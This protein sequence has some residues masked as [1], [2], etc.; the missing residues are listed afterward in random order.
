MNRASERRLQSAGAKA[1]RSGSWPLTTSRTNKTLRMN[2]SATTLYSLGF[3]WLA[4]SRVLLSAHAS[5]PCAPVATFADGRSP[6]REWFVSPAGSDSTG[7]GSRAN[8]FRS[9]TRAA[10]R[11]RPGDAIRL[12][13]GTHSPGIYL[14]NLAGTAEAPIWLGGIPG[15]SRPVIAGGSQALHLVRTRYLV[16]EHL[17]VRDATQNGI[18]CDDGGDYANP[19][20]TRHVIFRNLFLHDIGTGGNQDALKLSGVNDY[21]V[22]DC[23]FARTSAGGSGIDHVGCHRGRIVGCRF[24]DM[25]SNAIQCKG[26][27]EDLEI[28]ACQF[29]EGGARA[30]NLGGSTGFEFFRPPLSTSQPNVEARNIRVLASLFRGADAPVAFVGAVDS[31]FANNTIVEP[32][33][34][35]L[36][37]LQETTST[38]PYTFLPCASNRFVNNLV[39]FDRAQLSTFA[40]IGPNTASTTFRFA[41]N[42]WYAADQPARSQPNLPTPE[43]ASVVGRDPRFTDAAA[44]DYS[45]LELSPAAGAGLHLDQVLSDL[46]FRCYASPPSIGAFEAR[47]S[48]GPDADADGD[49]LPDAWERAYGLNPADPTDALEDHD[50]DGLPNLGEFM[51]GTDPRDPHSVLRLAFPSRSPAGLTF[52]YPTVEG[53]RYHLEARALG[54]PSWSAVRTDTGLGTLVEYTSPIVGAGVLFRVKAERAR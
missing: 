22:L 2:L 49:Q 5:P 46:R 18:N 35:V 6:L 29:L 51:A 30:I 23:E 10:S 19:D 24:T 41:H 53:R 14:A 43:T 37:I 42:L 40:N 32:R 3:A 21:W 45:I 44:G 12:L 27:S 20:A 50:A 36:R 33:R 11:V 7:T 15:E 8:P 54:D 34:W 47:P 1:G 25:G 17:E 39:W 28:R 26:G 9:V 13:P 38:V 48:P 31:L 16:L 4:L 52:T